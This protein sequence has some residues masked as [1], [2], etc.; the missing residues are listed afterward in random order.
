M[1]LFS[2]GCIWVLRGTT[3]QG[4]A[5]DQLDTAAA[6]KSIGTVRFMGEG[7]SCRELQID[8]QT[9]RVSEKK[10]AGDCKETRTPTDPQEVMK[11]RYSGGRLESIRES[12]SGR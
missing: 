2:A 11:S 5:P 8:N 6:A 4:P 1:A 12:F 9:G 7:Q 3:A 10:R